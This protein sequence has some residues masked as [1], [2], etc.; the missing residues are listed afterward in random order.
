[1]K[2]NDFLLKYRKPLFNAEGGDGGGGDPAPAAAPAAPAAAAGG[3]DAGG[4]ADTALGNAAPGAPEGGE[5][6]EAE[7]GDAGDEKNGE[8]AATPEDFK[9]SAPEGM[10]QF[11]GDFDAYSSEAATWMQE[12]PAATA[13]EA[14]KWA[15]D[16]QAAAVSEQAKELQQSFNDQVVQWGKDA[17]AD[18][19]IGGDKYAENVAIASKAIEAFGSPELRTLLNES[20]LGNH[21]EMIRFATK[22]GASIS[23]SPVVKPSGGQTRG[24]LASRLY[25]KK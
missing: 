15:A 12:N 18:P 7:G 25:P 14:L 17:Q 9:L 23:E 8:D 2:I 22:A 13:S 6:G 10:E 5:G 24:S 11:Q 21:P 3:D 19:E 16:R 20:G 1:M 4:A